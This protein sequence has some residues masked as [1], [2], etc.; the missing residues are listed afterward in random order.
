LAV[1]AEVVWFYTQSRWLPLM[2][3]QAWLLLAASLTV[4]RMGLTATS[5]AVLPVLILAQ[6]LHGIT[7]AAHHTACIALLSQHFPG[8]LR[9][10]G[11]ALYTV[12][13]YGMPGILGGLAGGLLSEKHGLGSVFMVSVVTSLV[14]T[15]LAFKVWKSVR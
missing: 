15:A 4:L 7:F 2:S 6:L 11:Q 13:G 8:R 12:V 14:A 9:G 1:V 10:R 5:A 3:L